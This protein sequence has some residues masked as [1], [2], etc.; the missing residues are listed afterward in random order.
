MVEG[1]L[2][3]DTWE[4]KD[5]C[6]KRSKLTVIAEKVVFLGGKAESDQPPTQQQAP[7]N[8]QSTPQ[9][10]Q[11]ANTGQLGQVVDEDDIP[12]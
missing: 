6:K 5:S 7:P 10:P 11:T 1:R 2:K 8:T 12:F 9:P 4:D 3:Q